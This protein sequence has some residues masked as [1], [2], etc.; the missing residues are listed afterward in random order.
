MLTKVT[1]NSIITGG[2][3]TDSTDAQGIEMINELMI[4]VF[5]YVCRQQH[6]TLNDLQIFMKQ[7]GLQ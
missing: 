6:V 4:R 1:P 7:N 5:D 3:G 2:A